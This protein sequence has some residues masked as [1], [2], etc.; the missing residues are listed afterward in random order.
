MISFLAPTVACFA[1]W[2]LIREPFTRSQQLAG[3]VS[4]FGIVLIARP[5]SLFERTSRMPLSDGGTNGSVALT[6]S[7]SLPITSV[8]PEATVSQ[9]LTGIGFALLGVCGAAWYVLGNCCPL[10]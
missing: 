9:R 3:L 2:I 5:I 8:P 1:C 7:T 10:F 4:L 6:N